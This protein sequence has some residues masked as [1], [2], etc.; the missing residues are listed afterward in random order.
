MSS[1]SRRSS[2]SSC[3]SCGS[4]CSRGPRS[5]GWIQTN[6]SR[7]NLSIGAVIRDRIRSISGQHVQVCVFFDLK[8][9]TA[10]YIIV[11]I[12]L[13]GEIAIDDLN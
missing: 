13:A 10:D 4:S 2:S 1:C 6:Q 5:C 3:C 12:E 8:I 11:P 7:A 9:A